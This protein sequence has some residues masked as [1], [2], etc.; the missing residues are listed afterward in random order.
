MAHFVE[1]HIRYKML[2]TIGLSFSLEQAF[3][4][5]TRAQSSRKSRRPVGVARRHAAFLFRQFMTEVFDQVNR[6][7]NLGSVIILSRPL[8]TQ[9]LAIARKIVCLAGHIW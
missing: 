3:F 2:E 9:W 7:Q 8:G 5:L 4:I 1:Q 6:G